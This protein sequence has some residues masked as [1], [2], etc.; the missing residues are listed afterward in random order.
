MHVSDTESWSEFE[1]KTDKACQ[2]EKKVMI[3]FASLNWS[4]TR[5]ESY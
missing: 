2:T 3:Q 4:Q 1:G 5:T